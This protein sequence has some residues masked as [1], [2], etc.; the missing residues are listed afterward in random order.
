MGLVL[1]VESCVTAEEPT[2]DLENLL[3]FFSDVF[4]A[5]S[6]RRLVRRE[7]SVRVP[8]GLDGTSLRTRYGLPLTLWFRVHFAPA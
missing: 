8:R 1:K 4:P 2:G 3:V 5:V 7:E 6:T